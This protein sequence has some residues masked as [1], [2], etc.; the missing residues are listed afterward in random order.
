M[1]RRTLL[2]LRGAA[3]TA[4]LLP[5]VYLAAVHVGPVHRLDAAVLN[6]FTNLNGPRVDPLAHDIATICDPEYV[7]L[8][9]RRR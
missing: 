6:G 1:D 9:G 8:A 2:A 7:R 5:L 4:A 3:T